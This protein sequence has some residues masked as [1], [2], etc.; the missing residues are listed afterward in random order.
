MQN[1]VVFESGAWGITYIRLSFVYSS[2]RSELIHDVFL[3]IHNVFSTLNSCH[4]EIL[5]QHMDL[6]LVVVFKLVHMAISHGMFHEMNI[7]F[8]MPR[9]LGRYIQ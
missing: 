1:V 3:E 4:W 6:G 7:Y 9:W 5:T 8:D 2:R